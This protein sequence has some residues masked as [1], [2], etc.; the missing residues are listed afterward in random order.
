LLEIFVDYRP[1]RLAGAQLAAGCI[2]VGSAG[3][4]YRDVDLERAKMA[5][6]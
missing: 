1:S 6:K 3:V 2:D 5:N 4:A